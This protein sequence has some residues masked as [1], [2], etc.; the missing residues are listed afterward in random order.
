MKKHIIISST[1]F[2]AIAVGSILFQNIVLS[3]PRIISLKQKIQLLN[4]KITNV[5][6]SALVQKK[7]RA[8]KYHLIQTLAHQSKVPSCLELKRLEPTTP[9][10]FYQLYPNPTSAR[11]DLVDCVFDAAGNTLE[12]TTIKTSS[13]AQQALSRSTGSSPFYETVFLKAN[14][15]TSP[16]RKAFPGIVQI[17]RVVPTSA[18][19]PCAVAN[20]GFDAAGLWVK[21]RCEGQ[22]ILLTA[23]GTRY[24]D[25][26]DPASVKPLI[27]AI[28]S[29]RLL[30]GSK[31]QVTG[32]ACETGN[33]AP[34][35]TQLYFGDAAIG[36][37][38]ISAKPSGLATGPVVS[39]N[40]QTQNV[41]HGFSYTVDLL[42][43][44]SMT[45]E[46]KARVQHSTKTQ[47]IDPAKNK[48]FIYAVSH[49]PQGFALKK[50]TGS[51]SIV[52]PKASN[53][54]QIIGNL[55]TAVVANGALAVRGWACHIGDPRPMGIHI[56]RN[57]QAG[58]GGIYI[59]GGS[60]N[61]NHEVG[62]SHRCVSGATAHRFE[63][64]I[65][66]AS[67]VLPANAPLYVYGI[68]LIAGKSNTLLGNSGTVKIPVYPGSPSL[69]PPQ[70]A[71]RCGNDQR[72]LILKDKLGCNVQ[73]CMQVHSGSDR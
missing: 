8:M 35:E 70:P 45:A 46:Q 61:I 18:Q 65:P 14:G 47:H 23:N 31:L 54:H 43:N 19:T 48:L 22:F 20:Y 59:G 41:G 17:T 3:D 29:A 33:A 16:V 12:A 73:H 10:G 32:W 58:K 21:N 60:A 25:A 56:Y 6:G 36:G 72:V 34:I 39:A 64:K 57:F 66:T 53:I 42:E 37:V 67:K 62:V 4:N 2:V 50:L 15:T 51:D 27:G 40:C 68:S 49:K 69:C 38:F 1:I 13:D 30:P 44:A 9:S 28:Q 55:D 5:P 63:I 7:R 26:L 11:P 24:L 71:L 52:I